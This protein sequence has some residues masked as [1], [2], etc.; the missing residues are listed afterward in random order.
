MM[1]IKVGLGRSL[2]PDG[3]GEDHMPGQI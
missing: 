1:W 2:G 3:D